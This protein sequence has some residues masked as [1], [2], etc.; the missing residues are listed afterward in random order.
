M[1]LDK[2][3]IEIWQRIIGASPDG[4]VGP[5]TARLSVEWAKEAFGPHWETIKLGGYVNNAAKVAIAGAVVTAIGV[6]VGSMFVK[7]PRQKVVKAAKGEVGPQNPDKY[8]SEVQPALM[9]NPTGIAWCGG[10]ALWALKQAG[11]T[12]ANWE[13]GKGFASRLLNT[14]K[15]PQPGDIAYYDQPFQ[16]HAIVEKVDG[17]NVYT[18]DGNQSPGEQVLERVRP[19]N[20]ATAY[21]SIESLIG[22]KS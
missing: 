22:A 17:N 8:W 13:I 21:Y 19:L 9:G 11:L 10:F 1:K 4:V 6:V 5:S 16:H 3:D 2:S 12:E 20:A 18:I 14:T 15:T 7:D